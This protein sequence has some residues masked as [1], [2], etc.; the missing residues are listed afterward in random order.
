MVVQ[1]KNSCGTCRECCKF[2]TITA[3]QD[4]NLQAQ[5]VK[6]WITGGKETKVPPT[7]CPSLNPSLLVSGCS[8]HKEET[9]PELCNTYLCLY[10]LGS[11]N[12][13]SNRPDNCGLIID[14]F[15]DRKV[16]RIVE[17]KE[18]ALEKNKELLWNIHRAGHLLG[19][20]WAV[21][22]IPYNLIGTDTGTRHIISE[23]G[24]SIG[25]K[26]DNK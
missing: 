12:N 22:I 8:I 1:Q 14:A 7:P 4:N 18:E 13:K 24:L 15:G 21:E 17:T 9:K 11:I 3:P 25:K 10:A 20:E 26:N 23:V 5:R 6:K 2:L 19:E 16:F